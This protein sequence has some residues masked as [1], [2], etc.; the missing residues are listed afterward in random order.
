MQIEMRI[1]F[2]L[3]HR[4]GLSLERPEPQ[5]HE[6]SSYRILNSLSSKE[7]NALLGNRKEGVNIILGLF[8]HAALR[9]RERMFLA[10]RLSMDAAPDWDIAWPLAQT[11][12]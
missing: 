12:A 9:A 5:Q 6:F 8:N 4:H 7:W 1:S 11:W 3:D 10:R 2:S